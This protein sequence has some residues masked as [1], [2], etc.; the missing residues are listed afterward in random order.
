M[1]LDTAPGHGPSTS[2]WTR[3][4]T[5]P[6]GRCRAVYSTGIPVFLVARFHQEVE[7]L[8]LSVGAQPRM[9]E[10]SVD[11]AWTEVG[12]MRVCR[13]HIDVPDDA[14]AVALDHAMRDE[15]HVVDIERVPMTEN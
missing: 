1:I 2:R 13:T 9:T 8:A 12:P 4:A 10:V 5:P 7:R 14:V 15:W 11:V 6:R 3:F